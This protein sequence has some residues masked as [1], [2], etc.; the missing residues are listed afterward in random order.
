M[1]VV[2]VVVKWNKNRF[3]LHPSKCAYIYLNIKR[4][5]YRLALLHIQVTGYKK[6]VEFL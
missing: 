3:Y 4:N 6:N 2:V 5:T 1:T